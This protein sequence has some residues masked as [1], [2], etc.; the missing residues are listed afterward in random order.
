MKNFIRKSLTIALMALP[1]TFLSSQ[2]NAQT[3]AFHGKITFIEPS[4]MPEYFYLTADNGSTR[5]PAGKSLKYEKRSDNNII[6]QSLLVKA[7]YEGKLTYLV[8]DQ[9]CVVQ[10]VHLFK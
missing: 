8:V 6:L 1:L 2:A 10:Y 7:M 5:C 9:N 4:Y 3:E